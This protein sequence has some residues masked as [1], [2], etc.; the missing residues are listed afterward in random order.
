MSY[1]DD[2]EDPCTISGPRAYLSEEGEGRSSSFREPWLAAFLVAAVAHAFLAGVLF[3]WH[4][5]FSVP[6]G[7]GRPLFVR[8]CEIGHQS[9]PQS[10]PQVLPRTEARPQETPARA[11]VRQRTSPSR[12][13]PAPV[14]KRDANPV[15]PA[16]PSTPQKIDPDPSEGPKTDPFPADQAPSAG[17]LTG[18]A[19]TAP[20]PAVSG[21]GG[22]ARSDDVLP[23]EGGFEERVVDTPPVA[24]HRP[25][26]HYPLA[27]RRR[28][29][30]GEVRVRFLVDESGHVQSVRIVEGSPSGVFDEAVRD[31]VP[32]W[33]F[34]PGRFRGRSVP[35]WCETSVVFRLE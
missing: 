1:W 12:P 10:T 16:L 22:A 15:A 3:R 11:R 30:T 32:R 20:D 19:E 7:P 18:H 24:V 4:M 23:V 26:P 21:S 8:I 14:A 27:A 34:R 29:L 28:N 6:P 2:I 13:R 5:E 31:V 35:V 17:G 25:A 9:G 33:Q